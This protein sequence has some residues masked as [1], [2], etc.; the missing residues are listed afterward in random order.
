MRNRLLD[1]APLLRLAVCMII[2][3]TIANYIVLPLPMLPVF[4]GMVVIALLLGSHRYLQSI[5]ILLCFLLMGMFLMQRQLSLPDDSQNISRI[6]RSK[7]FFLSQ[8]TKL[9]DRFANHGVD[10]DAYAV[11]AAMSLGDKS[12][13]TRDLKETYSI[14]SSR[15]NAS[16]E[17]SKDRYENEKFLGYTH[18]YINRLRAQIGVTV[19]FNKHHELDFYL[20][21]DRYKDKE[22]DTNREGSESWQ[23]NGLV[24]KSIEW[25]TGNMISAG[26]GYK[27]SF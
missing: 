5:A 8:R 20:L 10:G 14:S 13:L 19:K 27:W 25:H 16:A 17:K 15:Y 1:N 18:A 6:E 11:V 7:Q 26:V 4:A 22:I 23:E 12:A 24:L 2:G 21:G 3:I 9:L